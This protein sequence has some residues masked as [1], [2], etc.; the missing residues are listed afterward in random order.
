M[1]KSKVLSF[2]TLSKNTKKIL[3]PLSSIAL[4]SPNSIKKHIYCRHSEWTQTIRANFYLMNLKFLSDRRKYSL[5]KDLWCSIRLL[6]FH[7]RKQ[8]GYVAISEEW[9]YSK[10]GEKLM[11]KNSKN[12]FLPMFYPR[13]S[14]FK[15]IKITP[16]KHQQKYQSKK[17]ENN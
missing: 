7:R 2:L 4:S 14:F 15:G 13:I 17:N 3:K 5:W 12:S 16:M 8:G 11:W 1:R 9:M 6:K 10:K